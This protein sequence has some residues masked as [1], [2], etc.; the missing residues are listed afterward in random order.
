ML[1]DL[2]IASLALQVIPSPMEFASKFVVLI[3]TIMLITLA[4][5]V[6]L[7]FPTVFP[8]PI[9][10]VLPVHLIILFSMEIVLKRVLMEL[11]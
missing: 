9:V 5:Y 6:T 4:S 1:E 10:D 11:I 3:P 7:P 8:A 2:V